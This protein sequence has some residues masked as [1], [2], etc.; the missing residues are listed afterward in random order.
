MIDGRE[1]VIRA[2]W[3]DFLASHFG[4][5]PASSLVI[6]KSNRELACVGPDARSGGKDGSKE[7]IWAEGV[8]VQGQEGPF[9]DISSAKAWVESQLGAEEA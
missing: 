3:K 7:G 9:N 1:V 4:N 2:R 6:A 8:F 5:M